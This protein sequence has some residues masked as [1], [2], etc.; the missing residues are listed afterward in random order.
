MT[1]TPPTLLRSTIGRKV[2]M[3]V[4]GVL[5]FGFV[6]A[7]MAGNL[8][9][10]LGPSV[11]NEYAVF[12]R[13]FLHGAGLWIAR[14]VLLAAVVL[15]V[16]AAVSLTRVDHAARPIP[17]RTWTPMRSTYASRSMRWTGLFL[18]I[19]VVY[20]LLDL[21]F[22]TLNPGFVH[23]DVYGNVVRSFRVVPVAVIYLVAMVLLGLHL[24]HG[25]I[26]M[27]QTLG[28]S[29]PRHLALAGRALTL[30]VGVTI[31]ANMSF[32]IAVLIGVVR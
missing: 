27:L 13:E 23:G 32:P 1:A 24:K 11:M 21:T 28:V 5:L 25:T 30:L 26:G 17:Y 29:H 7:H 4:T 15:H 14:A 6:V 2:V 9:L 8:Q 3:A 16:W 22:G 10:Y 19:F 31:L 12:L 20:H 18:A